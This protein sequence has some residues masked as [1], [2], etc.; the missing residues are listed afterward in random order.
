MKRSSVFYLLLLVVSVLSTAFVCIHV[1]PDSLPVFRSSSLQEKGKVTF[2]EFSLDVER[3]AHG[4]RWFP[5]TYKLHTKPVLFCQKILPCCWQTFWG[6]TRLLS[7]FALCSFSFRFF[8]SVFFLFEDVFALICENY[9]QYNPTLLKFLQRCCYVVF[10]S[11]IPPSKFL[12]RW[13]KQ[14][15]AYELEQTSRSGNL[16]AFLL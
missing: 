4:M 9:I 11:Q 1:V 8:F 14:Q 13:K 2:E 6:N 16:P 12:Q 3:R 7:C 15:G 10:Y 5:A